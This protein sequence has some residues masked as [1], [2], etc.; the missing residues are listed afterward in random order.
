MTIAGARAGSAY[1]V[2]VNGILYRSIFD[3]ADKTGMSNVWLYTRLSQKSGAPVLIKK[4][5]V[6]T[7][8][9]IRSRKESYEQY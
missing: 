1:P 4:Q 8:S 7:Q 9:W 3:A 6:V 2:F 5:V